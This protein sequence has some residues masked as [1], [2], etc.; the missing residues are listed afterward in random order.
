MPCVHAANPDV[1]SWINEQNR[2]AKTVQEQL[3]SK[4]STIHKYLNIRRKAATY[5]L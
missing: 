2:M 1:E 3:R 4:Q 5:A